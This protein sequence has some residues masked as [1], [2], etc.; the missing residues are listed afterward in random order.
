MQGFFLAMFRQETKPYFLLASTKCLGLE[1]HGSNLAPRD[2]FGA[3][4]VGF[5]NGMLEPSR[6]AAVV[7]LPGPKPGCYIKPP[8]ASS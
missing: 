2:G 1:A 7:C 6:G 4:L 5:G 3:K 8:L